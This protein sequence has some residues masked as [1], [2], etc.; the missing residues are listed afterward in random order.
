MHLT[1][2]RREIED[3]VQSF[4]LDV[5]EPPWFPPAVPLYLDSGRPS[6]LCDNKHRCYPCLISHLIWRKI[7]RGE[8][9]QHFSVCYSTSEL[10]KTSSHTQQEEQFLTWHMF[11]ERIKRIT[12]KRSLFFFFPK[13]WHNSTVLHISY[14]VT[15]RQMCCVFQGSSCDTCVTAPR[16]KGTLQLELDERWDERCLWSNCAPLKERQLYISLL[17]RVNIS[18][19]WQSHQLEGKTPVCV[20]KGFKQ[21]K[22]SL[23]P[24]NGKL[25]DTSNQDH[26]ES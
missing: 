15:S 2:Q 14:Q 4:C 9:Q 20:T 8:K 22:H 12:N 13:A 19:C 7:C 24:P 25:R 17:L 26:S 5:G 10:T 21:A 16:Y 23:F 18:D 11:T 3:M 6:S 1:D